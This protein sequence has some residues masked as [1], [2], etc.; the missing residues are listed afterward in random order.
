MPAKKKGA[1]P[2]FLEFG[3]PVVRKAPKGAK[4]ADLVEAL[5]HAV[6]TGRPPVGWAIDTR[7]RNS[8]TSAYK[9]AP[10]ERM[11]RESGNRG[12]DF[13]GIFLNRYLARQA[14]KFGVDLVQPREA[15]EAEIRKFENAQERIRERESGEFEAAGFRTKKQKRSDAARKGA[16]TRARRKE[17]ARLEE[18][19]A[20]KRKK[21][22]A[23]KRKAAAMERKRAAEAAAAKRAE[24]ARRGW[25]ARRAAARK[26]SE[27]ARRGWE[28]RQKNQRRKR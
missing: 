6:I 20:I 1:K 10:V 26:R 25:E 13:N 27:A 14:D 15:T 5:N 17:Q 2:R 12:G 19:A 28:T 18:L 8:R 24:A 3:S 7:W 9:S 22:Q 4:P 21:A 16:E 23:L 11:L